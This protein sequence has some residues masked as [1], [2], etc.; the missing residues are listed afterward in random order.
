MHYRCPVEK[1]IMHQERKQPSCN[2]R[3]VDASWYLSWV[4]P[5]LGNAD[6]IRDHSGEVLTAPIP[7]KFTAN[8]DS[9]F[10]FQEPWAIVDHIDPSQHLGL[11][12]PPVTAGADTALLPTLRS[13]HHMALCPK[14]QHLVV[15]SGEIFDVYA[16]KPTNGRSSPWASTPV[17]GASLRPTVA[18]SAHGISGNVVKAVAFLRPLM[19]SIVF[20]RGVIW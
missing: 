9:I 19:L 8:C 3:I 13:V 12:H 10:L 11:S 18:A 4:G 17:N 6:A 5:G 1:P 15:F 20:Q 16:C 14:G 7:T 2:C